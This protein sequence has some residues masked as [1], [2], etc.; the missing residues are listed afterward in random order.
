VSF[1][2]RSLTHYDLS[3]CWYTL[4]VGKS[5]CLASPKILSVASPQTFY[6]S[7]PCNLQF[8]AT[9]SHSALSTR[10]AHPAVMVPKR[11]PR[12][13]STE[14]NK[15]KSLHFVPILNNTNS[16]IKF[17]ST[18]F[19]YLGHTTGSPC[20]RLTDSVPYTDTQVCFVL[21]LYNCIPVPSS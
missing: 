20:Q 21:A 6:Y 18:S 10:A 3:V 2:S 5:P 16:F 19:H 17:S 9:I 7:L 1:R 8:S 14:S 4:S 13:C 12:V 15:S 11:K